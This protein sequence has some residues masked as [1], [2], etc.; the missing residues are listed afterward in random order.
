MVYERVNEKVNEHVMKETNMMSLSKAQKWF[1]KTLKEGI[2]K[3]KK[4]LEALA[5]ANHKESEKD[6]RY[7]EN[8][9]RSGKKRTVAD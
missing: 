9:D 2:E 5:E 7:G 8:N 3:D 6:C 1:K 4:I